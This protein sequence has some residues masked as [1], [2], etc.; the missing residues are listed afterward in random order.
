MKSSAKAIGDATMPARRV[1]QDAEA[2]LTAG[3]RS[4][5]KSS[6]HRPHQRLERR[7]HGLGWFAFGR[8]ERQRERVVSRLH[9][10]ERKVALILVVGL[11][12]QEVS[13]LAEALRRRLRLPV[14][15]EPP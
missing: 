15:L 8:V 13:A 12:V 3:E 6:E 11:R 1:T 9:D 7:A 2:V 5:W 4:S 10:Q 14:F